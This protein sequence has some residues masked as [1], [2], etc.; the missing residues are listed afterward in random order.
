VDTRPRLCAPKR[1]DLPDLRQAQPQPPS[2][3]DEMEHTEHV[4]G[5]HSVACRSAGWRRQ[6]AARLVQPK[7][8][9]AE[10]TSLRDLADE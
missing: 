10:P 9:A 6:N 4:S 1:H 3:C 7:G 2:L 8:L 5:V